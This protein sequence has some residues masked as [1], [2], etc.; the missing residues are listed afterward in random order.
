MPGMLAITNVGRA[1]AFRSGYFLRNVVPV[2]INGVA[3]EGIVQSSIRIDL[4]TG[5]EPHRCSFDFRGGKGFV[6]L[7]GHTCTIGHGTLENP[8]F[9][10]RILKAVRATVRNDDTRPT[11]RCEAVGWTFDMN[12]SRVSG[13]SVTSLAPRS[14]VGYLFSLSDPSLTGLGFTYDYIPADLPVVAEFSTGAIEPIASA[15]D[16]MFKSVDATW[17]VDHNKNI[18][19]F[20]TFDA[21]AWYTP[22]T[23][24]STSSVFWGFTH[25]PTDMSRVFAN[26]QVVGAGQPI[27]ADVD[28]LYHK[29]F[30]VPSAQGLIEGALTDSGSLGMYGATNGNGVM[31]LVG[32]QSRN[33]FMSAPVDRFQTAE[34]HM[35]A[36]KVSTFLPASAH[37]NT[38][39][40]A[41]A[42][43][44][45]I[46]PLKDERW[47]EIGGQWIYVASTLGSFS[48][49][50]SSVAYNY[51]I[52]SS[53]S[54]EITA[55][56]QAEADIAPSWNFVPG[57][58][59]FTV[60][61]FAAGTQIKTFATIMGNSP[62]ASLMPQYGLDAS[63]SYFWPRLFQD[64]RLS[65]SG[66]RQVASE[67]MARGAVE[68]W[69]GLEFTTRDPSIDIGRP[70]YVSITSLA[71]SGARSIVGTYTAQDIT[72]GG[73]GR[74][75]ETKG[76]ERTVRAGAVR[77]PTLW[78][79]LQGD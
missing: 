7:A 68:A 4:N 31:Y 10:G 1:A 20:L 19:A 21:S 5:E 73:F 71:E 26:V 35:R 46:S 69:E 34:S 77:R 49:T 14:I 66:A 15:L 63:A 70:V 67:A 41:A 53:I 24:T 8:Q 78:Q 23:L 29:A 25:Q 3:R 13:L 50:A 37:A 33:P 52:P 38:L 61:S 11:Y 40:V 27:L 56:I 62:V 2:R 79:I 6:P 22:S 76:P 28:A 36:G 16:R 30:P 59:G 75:S 17:Y 72:I 43:V 57:T 42:N 47:Y 55:D 60:R 54:G 45:S 9:V 18:K 44:N 48:L 65:P 51:F 32:P 74:L 39:T 12:I 58:D 64:D